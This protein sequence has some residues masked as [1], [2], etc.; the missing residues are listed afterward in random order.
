MFCEMFLLNNFIEYHHRLVVNISHIPS[1]DSLVLLKKIAYFCQFDLLCTILSFI[2]T[3]FSG[4]LRIILNVYGPT[5]Y[6][7]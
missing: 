3:S 5:L 7:H 2:I 4:C 6:I 1:S